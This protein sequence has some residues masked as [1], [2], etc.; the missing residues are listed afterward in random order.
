MATQMLS[1]NGFQEVYNLS[2]GIKAWGRNVAVGDEKMGLELFA[3]ADSFT[4]VLATAHALEGGLRNLYQA[5]MADVSN[6]AVQKVFG[7]LAEMETEHQRRLYALYQEVEAAPVSLEEF[8]RATAPAVAEGGFSIEEYRKRFIVDLSKPDS[9]ISIAMTIE[10]QAMDLYQ[11]AA[12]QQAPGPARDILL[13]IA[14]EEKAHLRYLGQ[15]M[16]EITTDI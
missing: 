13:Q 6:P 3:E 14:T 12:G 2:G 5:M 7:R 16:D 10:A 11:R 8:R 15:L 4:Q 1:G 9:A